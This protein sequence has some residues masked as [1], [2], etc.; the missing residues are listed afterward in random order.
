MTEKTS[1]TPAATTSRR[2][3][4]GAGL[5]LGGAAVAVKAARAA[6]G[7]DVILEKQDWN[8]ML[9]DGVDT[10]PYGYPSEF[11]NHVVRRNVAWL[12]ADP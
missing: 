11:E 6:N 8:Q 12:T 1:K 7:E 3:F 5:A 2:T 10:R 9:G 4:L